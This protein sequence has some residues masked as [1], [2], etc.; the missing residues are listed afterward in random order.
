MA[1]IDDHN[2]L[3]EA[4]LLLKSKDE[5]NAFFADLC[6][7]N[8]IEAMAQRFKAAKMISLKKTYEQ[9]TNATEISSATLS[10]VSKC[11][12]YGTGYK[13]VIEKINQ[14]GKQEKENE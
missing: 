14:K 13:N 8:E 12:Q 7:I 4:I 6:T 10:R 9:I 1:R 2:D 5:C 3:F 11:Y